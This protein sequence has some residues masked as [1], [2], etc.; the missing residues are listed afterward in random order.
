M[1][2]KTLVLAS[3]AAL[4][5]LAAMGGDGVKV[6]GFV[7]K[8][9]AANDYE[10]PADTAVLRK[11]REW[12]D[13]KFG[14]LFHYGLYSKPGIV[15]SWSICSEDV[16]WIT[17]HGDLP[18]DQ[19]K[20]WYWSLKDSLN[21]VD[22]D[23][24]EW[25]RVMK[26]GGM[27]YMVFTTKHH[28]GFCT[29]DSH[30][31]DFTIANGPFASDPRRD[32]AKEVFQA[33]RDEGFA[34]G[35]YF[36]KPDWHTQWFWNDAYATP[37]RHINYKKERHPEWWRNYQDY[38]AG[39]LG[40]L[41]GGR[42]GRFDILWLDGGWIKGDDIGL[43]SILAEARG[44][45]HPGLIAVDRSIRGRNE[46]YQTPERGIPETQL[47][48]P[49]E[50]CIPL[51]NDWG[52][53]PDAPYKSPL[54]V[55]STLVEV[56]AK[57]G[58][59]LL[60]IGPTAEGAIERPVVERLE[61]IGD[62]L[63]ANGEA[64]YS[65]VTTPIYRDGDVWFTRSADGEWTYAIYLPSE[66]GDMPQSLEW[67]GNLPEGPMTLLSNGAKVAYKVADG[68]VAARLPKG[69]P[70]MPVAMKFRM[71]KDSPLYKNST[72][73]VDLRVAD[74]L[75]RMTIEE[76]V[77]QL[78]CLMGW[79]MYDKQADGSV[80]ISATFRAQNSGDMPIGAYWATLRADP[81]TRKTL[82]SGLSPRESAR[83]LNLM[84]RYAVDS[85]RLG[86]PIFFAEEMPHGHMAIGT[87]V[88][89]TGLAMASTWNPDLVGNAARVMSEEVIAQGAN[90]G[91]GPVLDIARDPR[92]SRMEETFGE[93]PYLSGRLGAAFVEGAQ[94]ATLDGCDRRLF[95]T[96]KHFAAYG[97]PE[98]GHNGAPATVGPNKLF[99]E[100]LPPFMKAIEAG[101]GTVMTSYNEIDGV[102]SSANRL[103]LTETLR[104]DWGFDGFVMSDLFSIDGM[105]GATAADRVE[106]GA[107]ALKA[108]VDMDLGGSAYGRRLIEALERGLVSEA[109]IDR[110]VERVLR[111][112]FLS[113]LF[114]APYVDE[115]LAEVAVATPDN[116]G[117]A[118]DAA[119][120]AV[121][122][123]K[124]DRGTLPLSTAVKRIAI[125]G[126]NADTPYNQ[127]GDYTAPQ[128]EASV[129]TIREGIEAAASRRGVSTVYVKGCAVR[130][131]TEN[132]IDE[133]V[134]AAASADVAVVVVG[135]SSARDF[136]T[137]Y[138]DTGAADLESAKLLDM[139]C[140]EG[141]DRSTLRLLGLQ[142]ELLER[143]LATSTPTVVI[144]VQG[145]PLDMGPSSERAAALLTAWY[146]GAEGGRAVA[147]ILFGDAEP[148]GRLPVSVAASEG[149]LPVYY[150]QKA[151][152]GYVE[153]DGKPLYPFGYG[154][155]Y[156]T[157]EYSDLR[158]E[159]VDSTAASPK[160]I[161]S[162]NLTNTGDRRGADVAQLYLTD[163]VA[164]VAQ[165]PLVLKGFEK[166]WL[167][168]GETRRV[169][170]TLGFDQL[171]IYDAK[172]RRVVEPGD[173]RFFIGASS[174]DPKLRGS[175]RIY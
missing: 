109:D 171:A 104:D 158:V 45:L 152:R 25:A 31:T 167:Q 55:L 144:Y 95:T 33:F 27:K 26:R 166:V 51:S 68:R 123:L 67:R 130:D 66:E 20:Q 58:S 96:L 112:K 57:G 38:T 30:R 131:T 87:T 140:G 122:L 150:S 119:R 2:I 73:E 126:P 21:P 108:G 132:N 23:P 139:D 128:S 137:Q 60:G 172:L 41:L 155:S 70:R 129:T 93:D 49:W 106:A 101:S 170:V 114:D 7:H 9:S 168:P 46:N 135:G 42:Y 11:L 69:L 134:A 83:A 84:Q 159:L 14:V 6:Q 151:A 52:W 89:P 133:A 81:W 107:Q 37:N 127:L 72:A 18:Y 43:D 74:L 141:F 124:N 16:D 120:E 12:Q 97:V 65:T 88:F 85:T 36:S 10:W 63:D 22:F 50:S 161:V 24:S 136:K 29:F 169:A 92:W 61:A 138:L 35:C 148:S 146:P 90:I 19:Y 105:V 44:G 162:F 39:Q 17:R 77:G 40:E 4:A 56:V 64:V 160:V 153:T 113:G 82:Q 94:G 117:V 5:A 175:F 48:Y 76:K 156:T 100:L 102:P 79:E 154:L 98:G 116:R 62:W 125:V 59:L 103:L 149:Q 54:K 71:V 110:A 47:N 157:F 28:D 91:F 121:T 99:N 8:Q 111:L 165:P 15:E 53:V 32:M 163:P 164:S 75:R 3:L 34:I 145:R 118:L 147:E 143:V 142:Y 86:I 78:V 115:N 80:D 173:F 174:A 1:K 13:L